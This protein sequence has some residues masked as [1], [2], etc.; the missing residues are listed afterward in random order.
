[1]GTSY[2]A[3]S[4]DSMAVATSRAKV[5]NETS[6]ISWCFQNCMNKE[7]TKK[8]M[9]GLRGSISSNK[10]SYRDS[11]SICLLSGSPAIS[12]SLFVTAPHK[13]FVIALFLL[14]LTRRSSLWRS[15]PWISCFAVFD[16][17]D[18]NIRRRTCS[19]FLLKQ[20]A[21]SQTRSQNHSLGY[22]NAF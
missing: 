1:M 19:V 22:T 13:H 16:Y 4:S 15:T 9:S 8:T 7:I 3:S 5:K 21:L 6:L 20:A 2:Q 11:L 18:W 14:L 12:S 10:W 17:V